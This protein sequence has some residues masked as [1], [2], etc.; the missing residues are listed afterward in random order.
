M[1]TGATPQDRKTT[2]PSAAELK[3]QTQAIA[4][5]MSTGLDFRPFTIDVGDGITWSFKPDL[6]P[7]DTERI[8]EGMKM[9]DAASKSGEGM[10]EAYDVLVAAV[11]SCLLETQQ[12]KSLS[13]EDFPQPVYGTNAVMFFAMHLL[14]GRTG[15]PT[16]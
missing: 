5:F 15:F 11:Q 13:V 16:E 8:R 2:Q 9:I 1:T 3:R 10:Q 14:A 4:K 6:M 12:S 7:G